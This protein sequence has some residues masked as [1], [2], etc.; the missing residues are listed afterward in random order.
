[1]PG[2]SIAF[3]QAANT[4]PYGTPGVARDDI[5]QGQP[6]VCHS[7]LSG[8]TS[9][10]WSFLDVPP[11]SGAVL[12]GANTVSATFT[13]DLPGTYRIQLITNGGGLGNV[14]ILVIRVRYDGGGGLLGAGL[15]LP[16]FGERVGEDNVLIPPGSGP[17]N[18]R[19]Y[20]PF[21]EALLA[22]IQTL[23]VGITLYDAVAAV[24]DQLFT[25]Y[26]DNC[27][28][29]GALV[30]TYEA[31]SRY[32]TLNAYAVFL[33]GAPT[34]P[35]TYQL[36]L[37]PQPPIVIYNTTAQTAT[38]ISQS[39]GLLSLSVVIPAGMSATVWTVY[40][41]AG[42]DDIFSSDGYQQASEIQTTNASPTVVCS[43]PLPGNVSGGSHVPVPGLFR[44]KVEVAMQSTTTADAA[45]FELSA[46]WS[47]LVPGSPV[48]LG[49]GTSTSSGTNGGS[50]PSGWAAALQLD[51]TSQLVQV[52]VTGDAV[53]TVSHMILPSPLAFS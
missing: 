30:S 36:S 51:G 9:T 16:A 13:P 14:M 6:V 28:A 43:F 24:S 47:V 20:A 45:L 42:T 11:G 33:D 8:N 12:I 53:L 23:G 18:L 17:Q 4:I 19:G 44:V 15:C 7:A 27:S 41:Y 46:A 22:Y 1:M 48:S 35:F 26:H 31:E 21:F 25:A 38:I 10:A 52:V 37:A 32:G 34:A 50:P 5:W 29:G 39:P 2:A 3:N 49:P 40:G